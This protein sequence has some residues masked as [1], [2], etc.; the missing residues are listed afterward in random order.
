MREFNQNNSTLRFCIDRVHDGNPGGRVFSRRFTRAVAF[1]DLISLI[2]Q[3][4]KVFDSQGFPQAFQ[5]PRTFL[6][7]E[8]NPDYIAEAPAQ[9]IDEETVLAQHG[10]VF[11]FDVTVISRRSTDWQGTICWIDSG[12]QHEFSGIMEL[13]RMI[14]QK[15]PEHSL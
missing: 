14:R 13:L 6:H 3:L 5:C 4:D 11:T 2:L 9:G 8:T 1:N 12:E 7:N 15:L 10:N